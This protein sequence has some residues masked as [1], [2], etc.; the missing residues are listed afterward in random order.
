MNVR[1][2]GGA[3]ADALEDLDFTSM[4]S[5][6][7]DAPRFIRRQWW[8]DEIIGQLADADCTFVVLTA[9]EGAGKTGLMAQLA[10]DY[11]HWLRYFLRRDQQQPLADSS[12]RAVLL[13][14]G[15]Q[16]ATVKPELF[17][18][19]SAEVS[20]EQRVSVVSAS[21]QVI[22]VEADRLVGSPFQRRAIEV[23]Q[24]VGLAEG[25]VVG[26][27]IREWVT[28]LQLVPISDLAAM[29]LLDPLKRA[30]AQDREQI[31]VVL[32]ALDEAA[33]VPGGESILDWLGAA[34]ALPPNLR[35]IVTSRP[36]SRVDAFVEKQGDRVRQLIFDPADMRVRA[37]LRAY[38]ADLTVVEPVRPALRKGRPD[39]G[40]FHPRGPQQGRRQYRLPRC[41]R[42]G[43]R[44]GGEPGREPG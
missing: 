6:Y 37:E 7:I 38:A 3:G 28:E 2:Y 19:E 39:T 43:H 11:P 35:V 4:I 18:D 24:D 9:D 23:R 21:G 41:P 1:N 33:E 42:Q 22:G 36:N 31:V 15:F 25:P 34:P 12:A 16:L 5:S 8:A 40:R 32:D 30:S 20:V 29:A 27:H 13:R 44:S 17:P 26:V 14:I 10:S